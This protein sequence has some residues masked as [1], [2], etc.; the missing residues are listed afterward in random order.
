MEKMKH[1][2]K[3]FIIFML[4]GCTQPVDQPVI[5]T[6]WIDLT[7]TFDATTLYWPTSESFQLDTVFEGVTD[8]GFYYSAY[9]F[10][11]AEHGGT[12][13]DA[14]VHFAKGKN[15]V[16]QIPLDQLSGDAVVVN[17]SEKALA[18]PDYLIGTDDL[19]SWEQKNGAIPSGAILLLRTGYGQFWPDR[20][21]YMGTDLLGA[22]GVANLH[23]PGLD[24]KAA[25]WLIEN[26][27]IKALGID[28]PSIDYGQSQSFDSHRILFA[29]NIPA[30][31][32]LANLDLLPT[33]GSWVVALPMNIKGGSGG[34][35][36]IAAQVKKS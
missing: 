12:H 26:R 28:T 34:P 8:G 7:Y 9:K 23:F 16:D 14:P 18:D 24:P 25:Q 27:Q 35:L 3:A 15:S 29:E 30:F 17:V 10:C 13:L 32:N 19:L 11:G 31:E 21:K 1:F 4:G 6:K 22:E 20:V 2:T 36:R 5:E 33:L